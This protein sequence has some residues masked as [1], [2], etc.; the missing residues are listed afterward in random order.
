MVSFI[1]SR[2]SQRGEL[3]LPFTCLLPKPRRVKGQRKTSP[4]QVSWLPAVCPEGLRVLLF[5]YVTLNP[6]GSRYSTKHRHLE[7]LTVSIR[8][9]VYLDRNVE[10]CVR[11]CVSWG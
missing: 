2:D 8:D 5:F 6:G 1:V 9:G 3:D 4:P 10:G 11:V 7:I